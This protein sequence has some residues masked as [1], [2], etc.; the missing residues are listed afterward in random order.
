MNPLHVAVVGC[1]PWGLV[2]LERVVARWRRDRLPVAVEVL[3]VDPAPPGGGLYRGTPEH[4]LL[5]TACGEID[6]F[7]DVADRAPGAES[8]LEFL[9]RRGDHVTGPDGPRPPARADFLPRSWLGAYLEQAYATVVAHLPDGMTVT[10]L[11]TGVTSMDADPDGVALRLEDGSLR[12][13]DAAFVTVGVPTPALDTGV[14]GPGEDVVVAGMGLTAIDAVVDMTVGR[15]GRFVAGAQPG[16][17][18]YVP[19]GDEPVIHQFSRHGFFPLCRPTAPLDRPDGWE[20]RLQL[21]AVDEGARS[22]DLAGSV[23]PAL[24]ERMAQAERGTDRGTTASASG[25]SAVRSLLADMD[26][27]APTFASGPRYGEAVRRALV[28]DLAEG[29]GAVLPPRRRGLES[30]KLLR[31]D[32]RRVCDFDRLTP[33]SHDVLLRHVLPLF[34]RYTVGP[35]ASRGRELLA[36][37]RAGVLRHALG[38]APRVTRRG[39]AVRVESTTLVQPEVVEAGHYLEAFLPAPTP[40]T[41]PP[42]LAGAVRGGQAWLRQVGGRPVGIAVDSRFHPIGPAGTLTDRVT[43]LG[44]LTEGSRHFNFYVPSPGVRS[45]AHLDVESC[46]DELVARLVLQGAPV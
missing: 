25:S 19:S 39:A 37:A 8:F 5:N 28:A 10:H 40:R 46:V 15:G 41:L 14:P 38:P 3:V 42:F 33:E 36:L 31:D 1:G 7:G 35:P 23:L 18:A 12:R 26:P 20:P 27:A 16:E 43:Y 13:V 34:Y 22:V 11:P 4:L 6:V 29:T 32:V 24:L 30:M 45:R 44:G 9:H 17:L 2:V 21:E